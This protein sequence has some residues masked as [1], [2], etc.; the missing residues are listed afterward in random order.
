MVM[1]PPVLGRAQSSTRWLARGTMEA[2]TAPG[3]FGYTVSA[4]NI[5]IGVRTPRRAAPS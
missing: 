5:C 1:G 3:L 2:N 4:E